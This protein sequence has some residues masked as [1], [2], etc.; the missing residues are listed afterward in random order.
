MEDVVV[1]SFYPLAEV[2]KQHDVYTYWLPED[3]YIV[4]EPHSAT[5]VW[6]RQRRW[7]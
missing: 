4:R 5:S 3:E 7:D 2:L 6:H 1:F